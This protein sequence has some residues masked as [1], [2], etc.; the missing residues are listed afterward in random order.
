M[1][2]NAVEK[3]SAPPDSAKPAADTGAINL[4]WLGSR[5]RTERERLEISLRELARR[6]NVSPSLISQIERGLA[7]PSVSTLWSLA[8]ELGLTIDE[9]FSASE[10][11]AAAPGGAGKD[12]EAGAARSPVQRR[13]GMVARQLGRDTN[14]TILVINQDDQF[15]G[16]ENQGIISRQR[17]PSSH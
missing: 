15:L 14:L 10:R 17:A 9:L 13:L 6:I 7:M 11:S 5:L 12:S 3:R 8:T 2:D 4:G 1:K 16:H